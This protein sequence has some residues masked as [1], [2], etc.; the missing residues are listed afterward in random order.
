MLFMMQMDSNNVILMSIISLLSDHSTP[1]NCAAHVT[2]T[3][4]SKTTA[5]SMWLHSS[6]LDD[7]VLRDATAVG[8]ALRVVVMTTLNITIGQDR[9]FY[10]FMFPGSRRAKNPKIKEDNPTPN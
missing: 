7:I 10:A 6:S 4:L 2:L 9:T 5:R 3:S 1:N 8:A